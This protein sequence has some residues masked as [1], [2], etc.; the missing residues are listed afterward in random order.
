M[1]S[2]ML[3]WG[4]HRQDVRLGAPFGLGGAASQVPQPLLKWPWRRSHRFLRLGR[5]SQQAAPSWAQLCQG[6]GEARLEGEL[7]VPVGPGSRV[8]L[9]PGSQHARSPARPGHSPS[10]PPASPP[11]ASAAP[12]EA[13]SW[14]WF[15][16][17]FSNYVEWAKN[18][19][20]GPYLGVTTA[21]RGACC[22]PRAGPLRGRLSVGRVPVVLTFVPTH[23]SSLGLLGWA[24]P[25]WGPT[26][27]GRW[28]LGLSRPRGFAAQG[29]Q[30]LP[31][32]V[33]R[34]P[35]KPFQRRP[36]ARAAGGSAFV[37]YGSACHTSPR[38]SFNRCSQG[39]E[40][41]RRRG[42]GR[43]RRRRGTEASLSGPTGRPTTGRRLKA[44]HIH[45]SVRE[46]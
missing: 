31:G 42:C 41:K 25:E 37:I 21:V 27:L 36:A 44:A 29:G 2:G 9:A 15:S 7:W 6:L 5:K 40:T 28:L 17:C 16:P 43:R 19:G 35:P 3:V 14:L 11:P 46:D 4:P 32:R 45:P 30:A 10:R 26:H 20:S 33:P 8:T 12:T 1:L 18:S 23:S 22:F 24:P 38:S 39:R 13:P 34:P